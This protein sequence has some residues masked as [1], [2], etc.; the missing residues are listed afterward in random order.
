M[1]YQNQSQLSITYL[2]IH[3]WLWIY[4]FLATYLILE[5]MLFLHLIFSLCSLK[6]SHLIN[7]TQFFSIHLSLLYLYSGFISSCSI[8]LWTFKWSITFLSISVVVYIPLA[9]INMLVSTLKILFKFHISLNLMCHLYMIYQSFIH[10]S[11]LCMV[12]K[13]F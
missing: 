11:P 10:A 7:T 8:S 5:E 3:N 6:F 9:A 12:F 4:S 2:H 13:Y 1:Y